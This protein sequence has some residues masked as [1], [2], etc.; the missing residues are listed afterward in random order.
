MELN[1]GYVVRHV[2]YRL[3][4]KVCTKLLNRSFYMIYFVFMLFCLIDFC[5]KM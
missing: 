1:F 4:S 2:M 5:S 3:W